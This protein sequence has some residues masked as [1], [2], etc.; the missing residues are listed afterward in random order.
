LA[1][2]VAFD[3][4]TY[5]QKLSWHLTKKSNQKLSMTDIL[6]YDLILKQAVTLNISANC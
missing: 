3:Q 5:D 4:K 1:L 6:P 2:S